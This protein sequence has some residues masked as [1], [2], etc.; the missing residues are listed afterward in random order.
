MKRILVSLALVA[1][2]PI[3]AP[4]AAGLFPKAIAHF[5]SPQAAAA[6]LAIERDAQSGFKIFKFSDGDTAIEIAPEA[7]G[8]VF[9]IRYKGTELLK[10]PKELKD[11]PGFMYG[12]PVL[13]PTPNR[14]R[15]SVFMWDGQEFRF[16]PN[17]HANFLH[18]LVHSAVFERGD[19]G[20]GDAKSTLTLRLPFAPGSEHYRFFPFPH[21]LDLAIRIGN[22]SVRWTYTVD[23]RKGTKAIPFGFALH[24]WFLYQGPRK[25]TY[26]TIPASAVM[27]SEALLPTG[28]LL[29]LAAH[30]EYDARKPRSLDG[31]FRDD[32]YY[33]INPE[34]PTVID[35]RNPRLKISLTASRDFNHLVLYTP[36]GQPWFC[37]EDQTCSTDAH[38]LYAKGV[39]ND[40]ANLLIV[41]PGKTASGW[42]E[43]RF[44]NY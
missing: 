17:D 2:S 16:T 32:V 33:G 9:S 43:M 7:G 14:V 42:I 21:T 8:K 11:L 13:Y 15:D 20:A 35:F 37:V 23:N 18:G 30:S 44:N 24:P 28:K 27:E 40:V 22:D 3:A 34:H 5:V 41:E 10:M 38:N 25:D 6:E 12:V 29:D 31:F 36:K 39:K 19:L 4:F 1:L 26:I